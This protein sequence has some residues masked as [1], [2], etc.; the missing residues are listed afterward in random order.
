LTQP[1]K[2]TD[3]GN[4]VEK[5]PDNSDDTLVAEHEDNRKSH[6]TYDFLL[7]MSAAVVIGAVAVGMFMIISS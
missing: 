6:M 4:S 2:S 1:E 7:I 3:K 5:M